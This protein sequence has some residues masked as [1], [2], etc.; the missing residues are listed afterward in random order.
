MA[1]FL[2]IKQGFIHKLIASLLT[3]ILYGGLAYNTFVID[4]SYGEPYYTLHILGFALFLV[5]NVPL[6]VFFVFYLGYAFFESHR[7]SF[8]EWFNNK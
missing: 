2:K 3:L 8:S 4:L 1:D 5:V 7:V 6:A